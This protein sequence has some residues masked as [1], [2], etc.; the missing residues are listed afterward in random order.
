MERSEYNKIFENG[1]SHIE[2]AEILSQNEMYGFAISHLILGMEELI[3]YMVIMLMKV[4]N[5]D[6]DHEVS[7]QKGNSI[8]NNHGKK[9]DLIKEFY[10]AISNKIAA[11]NFEK[12][13]QNATSSFNQRFNYW[14]LFFNLFA[15]D[16]GINNE[17]IPIFLKW[18]EDANHNKNLGF[19]GDR[20]EGKI[21]TPK[22]FKLSDFET[23]LRYANII[24]KQT[25]FMKSTDISNEDF[26]RMSKQKD[27]I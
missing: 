23:A 5:Y 16:F 25:A 27:Q 15:S 4:N 2:A 21:G 20:R 26:H 22:R 19:Y 18:L 1:V 17:E 8:F 9:H 12:I 24:L 11:H 14:G 7:P 13:R 10:E 6:F 3:K